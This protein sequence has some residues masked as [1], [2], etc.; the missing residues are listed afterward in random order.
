M[1]VEKIALDQTGY[2]SQSFLE[3]VSASERLTPFYT[4]TPTIEHFDHVIKNRSFTKN[5]RQKLVEVL[6]RQYSQLSCSAQLSSNIDS[7]LSEKTFTITTGH[8]LNIFTGP[9]YFIYKIVTVINAAKEL[10]DK[11]PDNHFIPVYWMASEDHD[12]EEISYFFLHGKKHQW[13]TSQ[14]GAVGHF[15]PTELKQLLDELPGDTTPFEKAYLKNQNLADAC[16]QYVND[17]FGEH[18]LVVI[19][20]DDQDLKTELIPSIKSD[21]FENEPNDYVTKQSEK[22]SSLGFKIQVHC[23]EVNFFYLKN[24]VR[25]RI[26]KTKSG[27]RVIDTDISFSENDLLKEID[28]HPERFSPNVILRPLYQEII[29][30]NLAYVGGPSEL[31]YWL[32]LKSM[33]EHFKVPFP[34]L[35]PRNFGTIMPA[36]SQRKWSKTQLP[37]PNIFDEISDLEKQWLQNNSDKPISYSEQSTE[38]SNVYDQL[39]EK[40]GKVDP[41]LVRHLDAL[42]TT[43]VNKIEKAEKKL[44]RA[45]KRNHSDALGQIQAVKETVFPNGS[46]QERCDN[47]LNF[48]QE[49]QAFIHKLLEA[50]DPFDYRMHLILQ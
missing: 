45:E 7:L 16:R 37:L 12:F 34:I 19:D 4:A 1:K 40:A 43:S 10:Q 6:K 22:L 24:G 41:T 49:D 13:E 35:M 15:D 36:H 32:Q 3:Y 9:L 27:Y 2:F 20:A 17:L 39:I 23:R 25:E 8:Q 31:V 29:L 44:V 5:K 47:F 14:K 38:V 21:I 48:Y 28:Q 42:K 33:F 30:P 11:Y 26:E 18:G 46:L 50:F